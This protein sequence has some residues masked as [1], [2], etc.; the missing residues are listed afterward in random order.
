V[1]VRGSDLLSGDIV[2]VIPDRGWVSFMYS[3]PNLIPLPESEVRSIEAALEPFEFE[4]IY[5]AWWGTVIERDGKGIV[6]RSAQR[7]VDA[8]HGKLP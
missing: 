4:R 8:L 3:Y 6:R 7:Y 1:L 5:G 2:Q